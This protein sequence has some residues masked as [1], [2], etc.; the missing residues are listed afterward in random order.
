MK[1]KKLRKWVIFVCIAGLLL[2]AIW[3]STYI[4][5]ENEY[6]YV[7]QFQK[8]VKTEDTA[9]LKFRVPF[10]QK[11]EKLPKYSMMYDIPPSEVLTADKK[12]IVI[13]NFTVWRID[14]PYLFKKTVTS[15]AEMNSRIDAVVYSVVKN[16]F[17]EMQQSDIING[18]TNSIDNVNDEITRQVNEQ[19]KGY[20]VSTISVEIK[21]TDLPEAN[22]EA[23]YQRMISERN[24]MAEKYR[25]DGNYEAQKKINETDKEV[26]ILLSEAEA[27]AE[28]IKG[29]G[30]QGYMQVLQEAYGTP[31]RAEFYK[32][33]RSLET[34]KTTIKGDKTLIL[35]PDNYIVKVLIGQE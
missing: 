12:S 15:V 11:V 8:Y 22:E 5:K 27:K 28:Q 3:Q 29:E 9:G 14:D 21:R 20:G 35:G 17:G 10:V 31:E 13:D 26:R 19:L 1:D 7:T 23:V 16:T 33:V 2:I 24:Q 30:E 34:L 32:F 18:N 4:V 6:A 25:A